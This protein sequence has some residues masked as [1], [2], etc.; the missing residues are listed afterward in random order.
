MVMLF[1]S[2]TSYK[3]DKWSA[4]VSYEIQN[5]GRGA[6]GPD[7]NYMYVSGSYKI[8]DDTKLAVSV[9]HVDDGA[10]EGVG[11]QTGIFYNILPKTEVYALYSGTYLDDNPQGDSNAVIIGV[12]HKF[13]LS[14]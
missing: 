10:F 7:T 12:S 11:W 1:R 4:A 14:H 3:E 9:G 8:M 2:G 13:A 5:A 6:T